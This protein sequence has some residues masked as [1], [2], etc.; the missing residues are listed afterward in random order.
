MA[1]TKQT[2]RKSENTPKNPYTTST[3]GCKHKQASDDNSS[4]YYSPLSSPE[5]SE[6][7]L[8]QAKFPK[9]TDPATSTSRGASRSSPARANVS[10]PVRR[11]PHKSPG[12]SLPSFSTEDDDENEQE[13]T[14]NIKGDR[15]DGGVGNKADPN[16]GGKQPRR[17]IASKNIKRVKALHGLIQVLKLGQSSLKEIR[18]WNKQVRRKVPGETK[19]G[20]MKKG[21][22]AHDAHGWLLCKMKPGTVAL[23]EIRFY[24]RSCVFLIPMLAFQRYVCEVCEDVVK[25]YRWQAIALYNLQVTAEAYLV[26]VLADTNLCAIHGKCT[27]I[28]PKDMF[29]ARRLCGKTETGIGATMS[30]QFN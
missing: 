16:D 6:G 19:R 13:V 22:R 10:E 11:S 4:E 8:P 23:R 7:G 21:K 27:T 1:R 9:M 29:L 25:A 5:R 14:L 30:D 17:P 12:Y 24:Q 3:R 20:W 2:A 28:F 26:G 15:T 18:Q